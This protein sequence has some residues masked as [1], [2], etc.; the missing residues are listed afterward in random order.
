MN[1]IIIRYRSRNARGL[2]RSIQIEEGE[3]PVV[4]FGRKVRDSGGRMTLPGFGT[5]RV[6][7]DAGVDRDKLETRLNGD[8]HTVA[9]NR[10]S[11]NRSVRRIRPQELERLREIDADIKAAGERLR[12]LRNQR[13]NFL[14][15]AFQAGHKVTVKELVERAEKA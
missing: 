13:L 14:H 12:D 10:E 3:P 4:R 11:V 7:A 15:E 5:A 2:G 6:L 9:A 8:Y 1:P